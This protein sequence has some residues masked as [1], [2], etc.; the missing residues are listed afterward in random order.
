MRLLKKDELKAVL[1]HEIAHV[2]HRDMVLITLLSVFP[3]IIYYIAIGLM[4]TGGGQNRGGGNPLPWLGWACYCSTS[5]CI[6]WRSMARGSGN[7]PQIWAASGWATDHAISLLP[8]NVE[9][10]A[11]T[12]SRQR[13]Q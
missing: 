13:I 8:R 2:K 7:T 5:S 11:S 6:C 1:G 4:W 12:C 10:N 3:L 9:Y